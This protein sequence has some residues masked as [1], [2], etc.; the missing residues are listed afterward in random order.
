M[1]RSGLHPR[2]HS[3]RTLGSRAPLVAALALL[4]LGLTLACSDPPPEVDPD[5]VRE[6]EEGRVLG[7]V[8]EDGK[9]HAWRGLPYAAPPTGEARWRA[10]RPPEPWEGQREALA[11]GSECPQLGGEPIRGGEDCLYLDVYAPAVA[12][13]AVP[14][15][16]DRLPVMYW[17]HGG[18][19]TLGWGHQIPPAALAR[20]NGVVVVTINYRLGVFGWLSHPALRASAEDA[21]DASGNFGTLDM[22][23]GLEWVRDNIAAF[24]GDPER[25]T[26]FGESAGGVN[27]YSLLVSPRAKGLFHRAISQ[28]GMPGTV[29]RA[30]AEHYTDASEPGLPGSSGELLIA[31]L[32]QEGRADGRDDAKAVAAAMAHEDV[33][34]FLRGL[35][36][37]Q[38]LAPFAAL[39]DGP[40]P[41]YLAPAIIR[42]GHVIS[43]A[44]PRE[45]FA[46]P[47]GYNAVP[48][49]AGT[50]REESKLFFA[51]DSPHVRRLFGFPTGFRNLRL[52]D[53]E[54]EYGGLMW[55]ATGADVPVAAMRETQ[56][57]T[58]WAYRFDW[59]EEGSLLGL[60]LSKLLGAAHAI[61]LLFVFDTTDLGFANRFFFRDRDA[62]RALSAKMR[63]YW[64]EFAHFGRP[65]RGQGG[66]L[67]EW[68]PWGRRTRD[69]KTM[70]LDTEAGGG[71]RMASD[72]IDPAWVVE[73]ATQDPRL[74]DDEERCR[75]YRIF[76][77]WSDAMSLEEYAAIGGGACAPWPIES[78]L[79]FPSLSH[80]RAAPPADEGSTR[81]ADEASDEV[82]AAA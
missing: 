37:E 45:L 7:T 57:P 2:V 34:A 46:T 27:V 54:G 23:R 22:I 8:L 80:E 74:F 16:S 36:T 35:S 79:S 30:Q 38:I 43:E 68:K 13:E 49:I 28:S 14:E 61:E 42:D 17:I 48:F 1:T 81:E 11:S 29:T 65:G 50:N 77:Q 63:A 3:A 69:P 64:A 47:G 70:L 66:E 6:V 32:E 58:V 67:P 52:Y 44:A 51:M 76:V 18:G 24:G 10:P 21:E 39:V 62:A 19:N 5:S 40:M 82:P 20:D 72:R 33:E 55:R 56:G 59:D 60:D 41:L 53:V 78:R 73:R 71:L 75:V 15:G 25:V 31:L 4:P 9:V 12:P 26:I